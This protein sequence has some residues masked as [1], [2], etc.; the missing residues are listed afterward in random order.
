VAL[1]PDGLSRRSDAGSRGSCKSRSM[2]KLMVMN[3]TAVK[4]MVLWV[5][6]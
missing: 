3:M 5:S 1:E 6:G 4:R 2:A